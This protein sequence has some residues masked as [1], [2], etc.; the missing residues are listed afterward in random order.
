M[1]KV[2]AFVLATL[3]AA[4][5]L[6]QSLVPARLVSVSTN[7]W[8]NLSPSAAT[9]QPTLDWI[10]ANWRKDLFGAQVSLHSSNW[11]A[12]TRPYGDFTSSVPAVVSSQEAFDAADAWLAGLFEPDQ[13]FFLR[14]ES[15]SVRDNWSV[16]RT[17]W[18]NS[19]IPPDAWPTNVSPT[20]QVV[21][22]RHPPFVAAD[23]VIF[24]AFV[25]KEEFYAVLNSLGFANFFAFSPSDGTY[26][27]SNAP[28][29]NASVQTWK[30][31]DGLNPTNGQTV[32]AYLWGAGGTEP[33]GIPLSIDVLGGAGGYAQAEFVVVDPEVY[34]DYP[35]NLAYVTTSS[36]VY[37]F[38]PSAPPPYLQIAARPAVPLGT[39]RFLPEEPTCTQNTVFVV[40]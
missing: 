8:T 32:A 7:A 9:L 20:N 16:E 35:T 29:S 36:C 3:P 2:L 27:A 22:F 19:S 24:P 15:L 40:T 26:G 17:T 1:K 12:L 37:E 34:G 31:P 23:G 38:P 33:D 39:A 13:F 30:V 28:P 5:G 11:I 18:T 25:T 6:G 14:D 21:V 4:L 10:D